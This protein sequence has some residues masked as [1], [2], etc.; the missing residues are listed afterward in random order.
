MGSFILE[1]SS[2]NPDEQTWQSTAT[3]DKILGIDVSYKK[4]GDSWLALI[5]QRE[6]VQEYF[7]RRTFQEGEPFEM[8]YQIVR[9]RDG[10]KR[11]IFSRGELEFGPSGNPVRMIGTVQDITDLRKM[12]EK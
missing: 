7:A 3:M 1:L 12:N 8:E 11:W 5:V 2:E 10:Q 4:T 6:E 9:P